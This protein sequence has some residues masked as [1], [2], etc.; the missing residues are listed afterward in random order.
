MKLLLV[1]LLFTLA[2]QTQAQDKNLEYT[3]KLKSAANLTIDFAPPAQHHFNLEAPNK[4]TLQQGEQSKPGKI[5]K[6]PTLIS[7]QW[8]GKKPSACEIKAQLYVCD[9]ANTYCMPIK[10][11]FKCDDLKAAPTA[12]QADNTAPAAQPPAQARS[13]NAVEELFILNLPDQALA[14][15]KSENKLVLIDFFGIWCPPCNILDSYVFSQKDFAKFKAEYVFLKMDADDPV[16]FSLKS[17]YN[18]KG[19]PTIVIANGDGE[20]VARIVG[21]RKAKAFFAQMRK[22]TAWKNMSLQQREE[23]AKKGNAPDIALELAEYYANQENYEKSMMM[24]N[25]GLKGRVLTREKRSAYLLAQFSFLKSTMKDLKALTP[26]ME[27]ALET[28]APSVSN[29][30]IAQMLTEIADGLK[31]DGLKNRALNAQFKNAD[32]LLKNPKQYQDAEYS[33][34]DLQ[35]VIGAVY[36]DLKDDAKKKEHFKKSAE[37]YHKEIKAAGLDENTERG[38]N[39]NRIDALHSAGESEAAFQI[40][41]KLQAH[42]PEEFTFHYMRAAMLKEDKQNEKALPYSEK[43]FQYS[44]GDNRLRAAYQLASLKSTSGQKKEALKIIDEA[45]QEF[46]DTKGLQVR[47]D[48]YVERLQTLKKEISK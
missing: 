20:E 10:K 46:P 14:K 21:S 6:K 4:V 37:A 19:Y 38:N 8:D 30:M 2:Q 26:L 16:S 39:P 12:G 41:D 23:R 22:A 47:S 45:L 31:D 5:D 15:A 28:E 27:S 24:Y 25:L 11:N 1:T 36:N 17:K 48:R 13:K 32:Y 9:D 35:Y 34:G 7:A 18:V 40:L 44:Y 43:A 29:L 33:E 42:Y 3:A